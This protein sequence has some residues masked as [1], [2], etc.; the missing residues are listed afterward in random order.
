MLYS[1]ENFS[2]LMYT[3][4]YINFVK[5]YVKLN[6]HF[7][8]FPLDN[9]IIGVCFGEKADA[10]VFQTLVEQYS[11]SRTDLRSYR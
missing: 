8:S 10:R 9:L 11:I 3:E 7:Y 2:L 4:L 1:V 5:N 6:E